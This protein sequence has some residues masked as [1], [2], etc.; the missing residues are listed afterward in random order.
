MST[1]L[2]GELKAAYDRDFAILMEKWQR[3][4]KDQWEEDEMNQ[5][6]EDLQ[7]HYAKLKQQK[8]EQIK[9]KV[10][11]DLKSNKTHII[12]PRTFNLS[13]IPNS[14]SHNFVHIT[15]YNYLAKLYNALIQDFNMKKAEYVKHV[16]ALVN[17]INNQ[18][19]SM[20]GWQ[21][22]C[23][24]MAKEAQELLSEKS[25]TIANLTKTVEDLRASVLKLQNENMALKASSMLCE[26][27]VTK[28]SAMQ[29]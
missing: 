24:D 13:K 9:K 8:A 10:Q 7:Q 26:M 20:Q 27:R 4:P 17:N 23:N 12:P 19:Q 16:N 5:D 1:D 2:Q 28:E 3:Y 21:M 18:Y 6:F 11:F 25:A 15:K 29:H 14:A 22:M